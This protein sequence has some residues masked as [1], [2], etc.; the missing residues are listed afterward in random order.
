MKKSFLL[1]IAFALWTAV[2][3]NA[4][5]D[6]FLKLE[7]VPG[8]S[9]NADHRDEIDI[10]SFSMGISRPPGSTGRPQ[11]TDLS[12]TK[13]L[14][15]ASPLLMLKCAEGRAIPTAVLTCSTPAAGGRPVNFYVI[16]L[17]DVIVTSVSVGGAAGGDK[18][19]ESF[20]LNYTQI[21]WEYT[22]ISASGTAG[23][24]VKAKWDLR[25]VP[26]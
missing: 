2:S 22:P 17:T 9:T 16:R 18:P 11:F 5:F 19:T 15:K 12:L 4:A 6:C 26:Q 24:P 25:Q 14:D 8:E 23:T 21:E 20:S 10:Q 1:L 13:F 3:A 7:G